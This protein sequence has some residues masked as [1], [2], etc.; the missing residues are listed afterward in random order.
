M[1]VAMF[2][3]GYG[4]GLISALKLIR[5]G[6]AWG[7]GEDSPVSLTPSVPRVLSSRKG[8]RIPKSVSEEEQWRREQKQPPN[9]HGEV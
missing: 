7:A 1:A 6:M 8:K 4:V 9:M 5:C 3:L 2:L